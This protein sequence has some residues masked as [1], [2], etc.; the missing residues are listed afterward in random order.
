MATKDYNV[1]KWD[2]YLYLDETSPSGLR[3]KVDRRCGNGII[4]A[5]AGSVA[6]F[7]YKTGKRIFPRWRLVFDGKFYMVCRIMFILTNGS[8]DSKLVVDHLDGDTSNNT[9]SNLCLKNQRGNMQN[10]KKSTRN[11]SGIVGVYMV[12]I[13]RKGIKYS[14]WAADWCSDTKRFN[15]LFSIKKLGN[16]K[17]LVCAIEYRFKQLRLLNT[18]GAEYTSRHIYGNNTSKEANASTQI[19]K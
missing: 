12:N 2:N 14:Y 18:T 9:I 7:L 15:K 17:A 6:G 8:I 19:S 13:M 1:I 3:W 4:N 10:M 16:E 11:T 5:S